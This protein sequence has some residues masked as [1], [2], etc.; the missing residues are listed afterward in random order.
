MRACAN[1]KPKLGAVAKE[2]P[3]GMMRLR[4]PVTLGIFMKL[5]SSEIAIV[6]GI[7]CLFSANANAEQ[8]R[9]IKDDAKRLACFDAMATAAAPAPTPATLAPASRWEISDSKSPVDDSS[10]VSAGNQS[11]TDAGKQAGIYI[12]CR[13][14]KIE[15]YVAASEFW[16]SSERSVPVTFRINDAPATKQYWH[17]ATGNA[18]TSGAFVPSEKQASAFI[19][20]LP[21][22]GRLFLRVDDFQGIP[23]DM[24]FALD[25]ITEV[26]SRLA[27]AC[28]AKP[29]G[30]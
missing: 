1:L 8:C 11:T 14:H 9:D 16:G 17:S 6:A 10:Q 12:R 2:N 20:S 27:E 18:L 29:R 23:H 28:R 21:E 25:G 5:F 24:T 19:A 22:N 26:K 30:K 3:S 7:F 15:A 13:E 4:E